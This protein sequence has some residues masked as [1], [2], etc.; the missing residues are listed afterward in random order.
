M[1]SCL[2]ESRFL[3]GYVRP[4]NLPEAVAAADMAK[5]EIAYVVSATW[6]ARQF[7]DLKG[8]SSVPVEIG[9]RVDIL[10]RLGDEGRRYILHTEEGSVELLLRQEPA[11]W[12][13]IKF[14]GNPFDGRFNTTKEFK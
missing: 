3:R 5:P 10:P 2:V 7:L 11:E 13:A 6:H 14:F 1:V 9:Q 8:M 4:A 12:L